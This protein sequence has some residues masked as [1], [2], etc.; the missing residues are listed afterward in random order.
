MTRPYF[1]NRTAVIL[2][3]AAL[4]FATPS[5]A[6][7]AD[8]KSP[9]PVPPSVDVQL[10]PESQAPME[11]PP[12]IEVPAI[13]APPAQSPEQAVKI[14]EVSQKE[15]TISLDLK[16]IDITELF[17]IFSLKMG[18][19]IVPSKSVSGRVSIFLNN[20]SFNDALDIVLISQDLAAVRMGKIINIMTAAEY[21]KAYGRKYNEKRMFTSLKLN[22]AKPSTVFNVLT[23]L[24]SDIGKIIVDESSGTILL[25]D[26]P[27]K[28]ELMKDTVK[29]LDQSLPTEIYDIKYA[30]SADMKTQLSGTITAGPG[31]LLVDER[32]SKVAVSDLPEKMLKIRRIMKA[33]DSAPQQ[34]FIEAEIIELT[35]DKKFERGIEWDKFFTDEQWV[36]WAKL[37]GLTLTGTYPLAA[38]ALPGAVATTVEIGQNYPNPPYAAVIKF[39]QTYGDT[40][41]LSRPRI[42]VVSNQEARIMVGTR[43]AY[44]TASQSQSS[45]GPTI[46]AENVQF[47]DVGVK[48]NVVPVIN[49]D[50]FITMKIKPE[51]SSVKDWLRTAAGTTVPIVNTSEAETVVKVKDGAM[52]MIAGLMKDTRTDDVKGIPPFAKIPWLGFIFGNRTAD[53]K[54]EEIIVFITPHI[55]TGEAI[56]PGTEPEKLISPD[57]VTKGIREKLVGR[58]VDEIVPQGVDGESRK[59]EKKAFERDV[60]DTNIETKMKGLKRY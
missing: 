44:I 15:K 43:E 40:K 52:I 51:I 60:P 21:E 54:R 25:I 55:I 37:M 19:S 1:P 26:I 34:V 3:A 30:K 12:S 8:E 17:R 56:V 10:P 11:M 47:I 36:K 14:D 41:I 22:Y 28:I 39:L 48:L 9:A 53:T 31:E 2:I 45:A 35:L 24:K 7:N 42:A 18:L 58:K 57:M 27:E 38:F 29:E 23:Q 49:T 46:T 13:I 5:V 16:G 32:S 33:F 4:L 50:G 20:L 59:F 6:Q